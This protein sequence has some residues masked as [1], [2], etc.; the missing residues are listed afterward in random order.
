MTVRVLSNMWIAF[1]KTISVSGLISTK[2]LLQAKWLC[3]SA[4][5]IIG[6]S[7]TLCFPQKIVRTNPLE[8]TDSTVQPSYVKST[9][10]W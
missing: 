3:G 9:S 5:P 4:I 1:R 10:W 2:H 7:Q 6:P 8:I